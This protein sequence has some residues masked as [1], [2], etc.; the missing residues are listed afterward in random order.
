M[1]YRKW[2]VENAQRL[3]AEVGDGSQVIGMDLKVVLLVV[4]RQSSLAPKTF[5][6]NGSFSNQAVNQHDT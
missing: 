2:N 5:Q 6:L 1:V 4:G 3:E